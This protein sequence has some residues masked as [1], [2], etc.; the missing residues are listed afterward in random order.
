MEEGEFSEARKLSFL[1]TFTNIPVHKSALG[2]HQIILR[3]DSLREHTAHRNIVTNHRYILLSRGRDV[4]I[5]NRSWYFIQT[6]LETCGTPLNEA[7]LVVLFQ[8]LHGCICLFGLNVTTIV[9]RNR[10]I[11]VLHRVKLGILDKHILWLEA[12]ISYLSYRLCLVR[13]LFLANNR[14]KGGSHKMQPRKWHQVRLELAQVNVQFPV[15]S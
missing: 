6:Y 4:L 1:H 14:C 8:P 15:K 7:D 12:V 13:S 3:V 5:N 10:H 2:I 9:N 11:L